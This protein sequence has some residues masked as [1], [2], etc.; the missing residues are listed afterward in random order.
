MQMQ[1]SG[2]SFPPSYLPFRKLVHLYQEPTPD[3]E[4]SMTS[5]ISPT[6]YFPKLCDPL[7][8]SGFK[9]S[10]FGLNLPLEEGPLFGKADKHLLVLFGFYCRIKAF[11]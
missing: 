11:G 4:A 9:Q 3:T 10:S 5:K 7:T 8:S 2:S 6:P 1:R